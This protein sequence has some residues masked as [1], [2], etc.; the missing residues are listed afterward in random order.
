MYSSVQ[1]LTFHWHHFNYC[2]FTGSTLLIPN[3][4]PSHHPCLHHAH[5]HTHLQRWSMWSLSQRQCPR[6][7]GL[8][9]KGKWPVT[10]DLTRFTCDETRGGG[11]HQQGQQLRGNRYTQRVF[12][13]V[14]CHLLYVWGSRLCTYGCLEW[15]RADRWGRASCVWSISSRANEPKYYLGPELCVVVFFLFFCGLLTATESQL[16]GGKQMVFIWK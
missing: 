3:S 6:Q 15:G 2:S 4:R 11:A 5:T 1:S 7:L 10:A 16:K 8:T 13:W 14:Q 9:L 12:H